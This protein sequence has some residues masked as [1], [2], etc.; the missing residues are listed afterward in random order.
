MR[1]EDEIKFEEI[2]FKII[3]D[4]KPILIAH[5]EFLKININDTNTDKKIRNLENATKSFFVSS[6]DD[7]EMSFAQAH[8]QFFKNQKNET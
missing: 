1:T 5:G 2:K 3:E 6:D 7:S 4:F 8:H